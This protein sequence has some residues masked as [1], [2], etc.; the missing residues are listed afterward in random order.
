MF[1]V[2]L[3]ANKVTSTKTPVQ[4]DYYDLPFCKRRKTKSRADNL[5]ERLSGDSLTTSPYEVHDTIHNFY[6]KHVFDFLFLAAHEAG[7]GMC[8]FVSKTTQKE[9]N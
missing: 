8:R 7:R 2:S 5:G 4:Y 9:R 6:L 3:K 1:K